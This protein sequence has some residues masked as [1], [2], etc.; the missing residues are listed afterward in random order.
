MAI[1]HAAEFAKLRLEEPAAITRNLDRILRSVDRIRHLVDDLLDLT[2]ERHGGV[3]I[4]R[5]AVD[6]AMLCRDV[7][8][9]LRGQ[10]EGR[11]VAVHVEGDMHG[12]WD[13]HRIAQCVSNLLSNAIKHSPAKTPI[14]LKLRGQR[15]MVTLELA[16]NGEIDARLLPTLFDPF[17]QPRREQPRGGGLGLGLFI[18]NAIACAHGG[19]I[20]VSSTQES[21]TCFT[22]SLP[23]GEAALTGRST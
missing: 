9:E 11:S 18:A 16:N 2:R 7:F 13:R 3:P 6:M 23:R 1:S 21:G 22:L 5:E 12:L 17:H 15:E 8:E 4:T 19:R 20:D 14:S 10:A